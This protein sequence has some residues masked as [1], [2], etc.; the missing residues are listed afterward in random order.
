MRKL[1]IF[2]VIAILALNASAF[3]VDHLTEFNLTNKS[4]DFYITVKNPSEEPLNLSVNL[5]APS[6][7][8]INAPTYI[9]K[10]SQTN[11]KI[12]IE[13]NSNN[14]IEQSSKLEVIAGN[15]YYTKDVLL[16]YYE[17]SQ[18]S[19]QSSQALFSLS[20]LSKNPIEIFIFIILAIIATLLFVKLINKLN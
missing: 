12:T 13:N 4:N 7:V 20:E 6:K 3:S 9:S 2:L 10:F 17:V 18:D 5:F 1:I 14:Y 11:I 19:N 16:K 15:N 8:T